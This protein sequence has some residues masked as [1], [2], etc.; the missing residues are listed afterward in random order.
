MIISYLF[1][2]LILLVGICMWKIEKPIS[3][4]FIVTAIYLFSK[5]SVS[6]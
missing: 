4:V 3:V 6:Y 5:V 2:L 1:V